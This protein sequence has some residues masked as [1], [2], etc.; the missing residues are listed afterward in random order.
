MR[1]LTGVMLLIVFY[2]CNNEGAGGKFRL[3]GQVSNMKDQAVYLDQLFFDDTAPEVLDTAEVKGGKFIVETQAPEEGL[4]RIRFESSPN[5]YFFINEKGEM[6]FKADA[7][8]QDLGAHEFSG[9]S[10]VALKNLMKEIYRRQMS[11]NACDSTVKALQAGGGSESSLVVS[12]D[13]LDKEYSAYKEFLLRVADT[14][15]NP[16]VSLFA[17]GFTSDVTP[18]LVEGT[19]RNLDR[20]FPEH[21]GVKAFSS[22]FASI[23][24]REKQKKLASGAPDVGSTAP[25]FTLN[26]VNG[27]PVALSSFRG[28]YVLVDFWASWC[29]PCRAEN[30]NVVK[31]YNAYKDKNFTILGV[32]LDEKRDSWIKAIKDDNL[33]W[34]Q[35]SDLKYWNSS[36][37][38][39]YR[40]DGIPYNVLIDPAGKIIASNLRGEQLMESLELYVK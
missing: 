38:S 30:P 35:V 39:L 28:K 25:D 1:L 10:N 23:M 13:R 4:Y 34:P 5:Q 15:V 27:N 36:V 11:I 37:V 3:K 12:M 18:S 40:F 6:T 8:K 29:G 32:S 9:K 7:E 14:C 31:A 16:V 20:R 2:S 33:N 22:Y 19:I 24:E 26:D 17:L 21:E